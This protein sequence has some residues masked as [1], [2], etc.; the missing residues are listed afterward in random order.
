MRKPWVKAWMT[1]DGVFDADTMNDWWQ[2]GEAVL[3]GGRAF[4]AA[5]AGREQGGGAGIP[6]RG[7][8]AGA[9]TLRETILA[10]RIG[11]R[12]ATVGLMC[13]TQMGA[14]CAGSAPDRQAEVAEAGRAVMPFDL[15]ATTHVFEKLQDGGLQIVVADADDAE[16]VSLIRAHLSEEAERFARGDFH[17]PATIHGADMPGL[18]ALMTGHERLRVAYREIERGAEIR[19]TTADAPLVGAIH[20]WFDAQ[21][22]DHGEHVT[23]HR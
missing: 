3:P 6:R 11:M 7:V 2:K 4:D 16:Q 10:R 12:A 17:D 22:R 14:A 8:R 23:P 21:V 20:Q 5:E 15:D 1:L 18:H 19:Y 9:M 13:L